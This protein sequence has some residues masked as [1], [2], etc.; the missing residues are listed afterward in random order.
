MKTDT[1]KMKRADDTDPV[2]DHETAV[3]LMR[4]HRKVMN[5]EVPALSPEESI[6]MLREGEKVG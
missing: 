6:R 1:N 3:E 5:G 2:L 4:L